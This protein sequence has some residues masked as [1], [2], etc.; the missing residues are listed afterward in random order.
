[1]EKGSGRENSGMVSGAGTYLQKYQI[2]HLK[3]LQ[4]PICQLRLGEAALKNV[5]L[6]HCFL[7][8]LSRCLVVHV[9]F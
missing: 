5:L 2:A 1:M 6:G 7:Q 8:S 4:L 9:T 3:H